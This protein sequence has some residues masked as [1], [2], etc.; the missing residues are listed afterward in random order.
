MGDAAAA[1]DC[2]PVLA[3]ALRELADGAAGRGGAVG[4]DVRHL[5]RGGR[6]TL[7]ADLPFRAASTIKVAILAALYAAAFEGALRLDDRVPIR[8]QD[9]VTGSG[10]VQVLSPGTRLSWRDLAELMIV[11]SDNAATNMILE[12]VGIDRTNALIASL[13]L[14]VMR[15]VRTLQVIPAGAVGFNTASAGDLASLLEAVAR[16]RVV[17]WDACRRMIATL[18]RQQI[19][20]ALPALLPDPEVGG[21]SI[22][23][24]PRWEMAHKTGGIPGHQHDC[25]ILYLPG[26][27]IAVAVMTAG[28]GAARE[29]RALIARVGRAVWDAYADGGPR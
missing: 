10:I 5:E 19:N 12:R 6:F 20:D 26:Q 3:D 4:I 22:G 2:P 18:K 29:A 27:T 11:V 17:S 28:C 15:V 9:Q 21:A 16:G 14:N 23:A 25:G 1:A 8:A 7:Q 13:G 24:F